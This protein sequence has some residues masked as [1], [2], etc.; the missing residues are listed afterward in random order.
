MSPAPLVSKPFIIVNTLLFAGYWLFMIAAYPTLPAEIPIHFSFAGNPTRF[1]NTSLLSWFL[2]PL[3]VTCLILLILFSEKIIQSFPLNSVWLNYPCKNEI[4]SLEASQ[5]KPFKSILDSYI[6]TTHQAIAFWM[7]LL[8]I[9]VHLNSYIFT[10]G[11]IVLP[12]MSVIVLLIFA[13]MIHTFW[14]VSK[15]NRRFKSQLEQIEPTM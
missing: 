13:M 10:I 7:L 6:H 11:Q 3:V 2:A 4:L 8:F 5:Q 1:A 9:Y 14:L 12:L 15:V